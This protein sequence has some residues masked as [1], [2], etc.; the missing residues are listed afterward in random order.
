VKPATGKFANLS[1]QRIKVQKAYYG[2]DCVSEDHV[3]KA[4]SSLVKI[5]P[6]SIT[7]EDLNR[8]DEEQVSL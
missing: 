6:E 1:K 5:K 7:I 8:N 2:L 3:N 4:V